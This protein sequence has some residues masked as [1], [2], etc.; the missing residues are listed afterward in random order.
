MANNEVKALFE[1][2]PVAFFSMCIR[3]DAIRC[4]YSGGLA[5]FDRHY[6]D[7]RAS[8]RLRALASM[9]YSEAECMLDELEA[10]GLTVGLNIAL[11]E[12]MHGETKGASGIRFI[13]IS[14]NHMPHWVAVADLR[15]VQ[16]PSHR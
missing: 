10:K 9:S 3:V 4:C 2:V 15:A 8:T 13:D 14:E 12:M 16:H 5:A 1:A 11:A 7:A 6:P